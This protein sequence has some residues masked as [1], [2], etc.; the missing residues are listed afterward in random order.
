MSLSVL[1]QLNQDMK[2]AMRDKDKLRLSVIRSV[3]GALQNEA[4]SLGHDL[5]EEEALTVLNREMKQRRE[6]LQEFD[7]A[8]RDD[9]VEKMQSEINILT[10]Y[11]PAQLSEEELQSIV[12]ETIE[13]TGASGKSDIGKV[14]G[15]VMPKV[16]GKADGTAVRNLVQQSLQ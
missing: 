1:D 8:D 9:L 12:D 10:E 3:K 5:S 16:K 13:E 4:I 6:S 14:M 15:A 11:L 2:Q 7:K